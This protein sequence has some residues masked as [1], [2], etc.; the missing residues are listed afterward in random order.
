MILEE[1]EDKEEEENSDKSPRSRRT[2]IE[3]E[4]EADDTSTKNA[5]DDEE[6]EDEEEEATGIEQSKKNANDDEGMTMEEEEDYYSNNLEEAEAEEEEDNSEGSSTSRRASIDMENETEDTSTEN[7]GEE[8]EDEEEK[9]TGME[10]SKKK[11][12]AE[13]K[14]NRRRNT[15]M[16]DGEKT[17][18]PLCKKTFGKKANVRRHMVDP[19]YHGLKG[20][21]LRKMMSKVN[22]TKLKCIHC[23]ASFVNRAKHIKHCKIKKEETMKKVENKVKGS[24]EELPSTFIPGGNEFTNR[25]LPYLEKQFKKKSS[26]HLYRRKLVHVIKFFEANGDDFLMDT[27]LYPLETETSFPSLKEY[28]EHSKTEG[29][30]K[31]AILVYRYMG[32]FLIREAS[33]RYGGEKIK[34]FMHYTMNEIQKSVKKIKCINAVSFK[35]TQEKKHARKDDSEAMV[36]NGNRCGEILNIL[37]NTKLIRSMRKDIVR[38]TANEVRR[39]YEEVEVRKC[40]MA[41]LLVGGNGATA[42]AISRAKVGEWKKAKHTDGFRIM[43]V[44]DYKLGKSAGSTPVGFFLPKLYKEVGVYIKTYKNMTKDDEQIFANK[45]GNETDIRIV[46]DWLKNKVLENVLTEEE[47]VHFS[48]EIWIKAWVQWADQLGEDDEIGRVARAVMCHSEK[49][50]TKKTVDTRKA[51]KFGAA[52]PTKVLDGPIMEEGAEKVGNEEEEDDAEEKISSKEK[53]FL[54][55]TFWDRDEPPKSL[56][57]TILDKKCMICPKFRRIYENL[58]NIRGSRKKANNTL[59]KL[60]MPKRMKIAEDGIKNKHMYDKLLFKLLPKL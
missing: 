43:Q 50:A 49:I 59:C 60:I 51:S 21:S 19:R 29:D 2:S 58:I 41:M 7:D 18:C 13:E 20:E 10:Q 1:V 55:D 11:K 53:K 54:K 26:Y 34:D 14:I 35:N 52:I 44:D 45:K 25:F 27:L 15:R 3:E 56:A 4:T 9:A 32:L 48:N 8:F 38:L 23:N 46:S 24:R 47:K 31:V 12:E 57:Q 30:K 42:V 37:L 36:H 33:R 6:F 28:I 16:N 17:S 5:N 22:E 40:L 39:K